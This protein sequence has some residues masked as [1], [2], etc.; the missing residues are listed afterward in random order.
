MVAK[1]PLTVTTGASGPS[2][3]KSLV[4]KIIV[5]PLP[6]GVKVAVIVVITS[7]S[8]TG[9]GSSLSHDINRIDAINNML[10]NLIV[11]IVFILI[12]N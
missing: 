4:F 5:P 12:N 1:F 2:P 7:S 6:T 10:N 8:L 11:F 3:S 9:S